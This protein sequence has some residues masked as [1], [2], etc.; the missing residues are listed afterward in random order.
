MPNQTDVLII[1]GGVIGVCSAYYLAR[2]GH[3]V[4]LLE[5]D[6]I[7][8]GSSYGNAGLIVPSHAVPLAT[9][10]ALSHGL[11]WLFDPGSP[12]YIKPR[13]DPELLRWLWLFRAACNGSQVQRSSAILA[14][15][16]QRSLQLFD[17]LAKRENFDFGY[18]RKGGMYLYTSRPAFE[19]GIAEATWLRRYGIR[20]V[21]FDRA[22]VCNRV[23][24]ATPAVVGGIFYPD[25]AHLIPDRFVRGLAEVAQQHGVHLQTHT[26]V[27]GFETAGRRI[28][29][30]STT[31]GPFHAEQVVLAAGAWTL[32]LARS[33]GLHLPIQP[34]K[35]YS[36]T[37]ENGSIDFDIALHLTERKVAVTPMGDQVRLAGT[38]EL[39]GL[40][41]SINHR[42][43]EAIRQAVPEYLT[44]MDQ[45]VLKELWRGLRPLTPDTLP[46]IGRPGRFPNLVI[47]G[48]H[49]M[50][51]VSLGPIT[52]QLVTQIIRGEPPAVPLALL[53]V[54]RFAT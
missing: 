28:T 29:A 42:R 41:F 52:G 44:G 33:L 23:P 12:L 2:Q 4:T 54:N 34:A 10:A 45:L 48:G 38:L 39:A 20:T 49:G 43:V 31:R 22:G 26:E 19:E 35:G 5:K 47:A 37:F 6:E 7:C 15:L 25:D 53:R 40:D 9:P 24:Q 8:A 50:L 14:E 51:G 46:I 16:N 32:L 27:L 36:L 11:R 1:G 3:S 17:S 13:L 18:C 30:V 21:L